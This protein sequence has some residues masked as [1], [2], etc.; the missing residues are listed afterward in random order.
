MT[1]NADADGR[2]RSLLLFVLH[3]LKPRGPFLTPFNVISI[4]VILVGL[5]ILVVRFTEGL[6][7]VTNLNQEYPWGFWIGFDVVT[8]VALAGGAYVITFVVYVMKVEN[9][10]T[11]VRVTVLN[12]FL[13]YVFYAG[14]LVLDLGK[15]W[16]IINPIIGNEFGYNSVLFLVAW[17]FLLYM[18][19]E[20]IEFSPAVAEWLGARRV[21]RFMKALTVGAVIFGITLSTLHQSGLGALFLMAKAKIHPLWYTEFIPILFFVSSIF[22]GLSMIIVEGTISHRV[23][24]DHMDAEHGDFDRLVFGLARGAA[25]AMFVYY[26]F[27]ALVF[28]HEHHWELMGDFWGYWYLLEVVGLTLVPCFMFAHGVRHRSIGTIRIAAVLALLGIVLNR[29]NISVIAF[30]W[31]LPDRYYPS[32]QELVVT[33][34][35]VF[36]EIWVFRWVVTRMPV[37]RRATGFD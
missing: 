24:K 25:I 1:G 30:N 32:W 26:F 7:S 19:A 20:F 27:K 11:L 35:V 4:P 6:G 15:P 23:L 3:E 37:L 34:A 36:T 31:F 28:I 13:A 10:H 8:G 17:H 9:Y 18:L 12:G 22:A 5:A 29:L 21:R 16:N 2:P 33:L 14:A